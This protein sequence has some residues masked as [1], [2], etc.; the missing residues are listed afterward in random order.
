MLSALRASTSASVPEETPSVYGAPSHAP[1]SRSKASTSAPR[2][3]PPDVATRATTSSSSASSSGS[4]LS[5]SSSGTDA[6]PP[7]ERSAGPV[8]S[9]LA[10]RA[11]SGGRL[12]AG[13]GVH[14]ALDQLRLQ[15]APAAVMQPVDRGLGPAEP[16]GDLARREAHDVAQDDDV[17]LLVGQGGQRGAQLAGAVAVGV[18]GALVG[19][20]DLRGGDRAARAQV[21]DRGVVGEPQGPAGGRHGPGLGFL[22]GRG[23]LREGLRRGGLGL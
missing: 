15:G 17:A 3:N 19:A 9:G 10:C 18:V 21:V 23:L 4:E 16:V 7:S 1:N 5:S 12:V 22:G 6:P 11:M 8:W 2:V 14:L 13:A 20:V